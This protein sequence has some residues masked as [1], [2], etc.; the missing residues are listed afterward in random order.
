[1]SERLR[2]T[3]AA[4]F[5]PEVIARL[6]ELEPRLDVAFEP[7]LHAEPTPE[8]WLAPER[9]A[10]AQREFERLLD[11]AEALLGIPDFK[12]AA[13]ARTVAANPALRWVH[14]IPAGG[15]QH[16]RAANL[17]ADALERVA[18]TTSAGVHAR[19]LAE[20]ALFGV[21][22]G[23]K[24]LPELNAA[25]ERHEWAQRREM[26]LARETT[27]AVVGLGGI[28]REVASMLGGL[29]MRIVGVH[30]RPVAVE[31]VAEI[32]PVE[33]LA[34]VAAEV[35]AIVLCLPGTDQTRE[36]F[37]P[38]VMSGMRGATLVNVG[39][40]T[41]VDEPA[42]IAALRDG[43][44]GSAVLDVTSTEPLPTDSPL[45]ELP[46]VIIS[47]HTAAVSE[48]E[49]RLIV[50]LFAENARRLLDGEPMLNRV[51]TIEFY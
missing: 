36:L 32:R 13:L 14:T 28:G 24:R 19:P 7:E 42:L 30:R 43:R 50:E 8:W 15:G 51:N 25:K 47:P 21:L 17:P 38:E 11:G 27:V 44:V 22:S 48:H 12:P 26:R 45:W 9:T 1:M 35:D 5:E 33:E 2:V 6:A 49:P 10:E 18:F 40:G 31:H 37:G 16:I 46:N 29:G 34:A 4:A 23:M 3:I 20:F 39:R 41:T